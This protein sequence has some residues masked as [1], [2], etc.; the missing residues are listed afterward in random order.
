M[1]NEQD[2]YE[3][4]L[5]EL[6][7]AAIEG[8]A[9]SADLNRLNDLIAADATARAFY[10]NFMEI[11]VGINETIGS[12]KLLDSPNIELNDSVLCEIV[13]RDLEDTAI[14]NAIEQ[15]A[16]QE[17]QLLPQRFDPLARRAP[18][19]KR[20]GLS[21]AAILAFSLGLIWLDRIIT[22]RAVIDPPVSVASLEDAIDLKWNPQGNMPQKGERLY[23]GRYQLDAGLIA[24]AF[25]YG[26]D[27]V[28]EAPAQFRIQSAGQMRLVAGKAFAVVPKEAVGFTIELP[29]SRVVDLGTAFGVEVT[30]TGQSQVQVSDGK[31]KLLSGR[32]IHPVIETLNRFDARQ[33]SADGAKVSKTSYNDRSFVQK[34]ASRNNLVWRGDK[35]SLADVVGGGNGFGTGEVGWGVDLGTGEPIYIEN[36]YYGNGNNAFLPCRSNRYIDGVFVPG[37]KAL[38]TQ[39]SSTGIQFGNFDENGGSYWVPPLNASFKNSD[40]IIFQA[41]DLQRLKLNIDLSANG[42]RPAIYLHSNGGITFDLDQIRRDLRGIDIERFQTIC[43]IPDRNK[44]NSANVWI[45][46][47]GKK[48]ATN[49][50]VVEGETE[51]IDIPINANQRFLTL[52][53]TRGNDNNTSWDLVF[54]GDPVLQLK[55]RKAN[56]K[57]NESIDASVDN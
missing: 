3:Y 48:V 49:K 1:L 37:A 30:P 32:A 19:W 57:K 27:V 56:Q 46:L 33:V 20:I 18:N 25:D 14:R 11:Y 54:F 31:V 26:T 51:T 16:D 53:V 15:S 8:T 22:R 24:L 13:E 38:K 40:N 55:D 36:I 10:L 6:I 9:D 52:A 5:T 12:L 34:I 2:R 45:L 39:V 7:L 41:F 44:G 42:G 4:D 23:P 28:V 43:T 21:V 47:D 17:N 50:I 29:N 35:L